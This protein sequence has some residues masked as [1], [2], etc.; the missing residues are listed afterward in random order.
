MVNYQLW[1]N[2]K[3]LSKLKESGRRIGK[4]RFKK[5]FRTMNFNQTGFSIDEQRGKL[6]LSQVGVIPIKLHREVRGKVKAVIV[7]RES[8]GKWF[9]ILQV[10]DVDE[11][12]PLPPTNSSVGVDVG[13]KHW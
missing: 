1:C 6:K 9:A 3:A 8:S 2:I 10:E 7:K 11:P 4:L 13:V 12:E 5:S